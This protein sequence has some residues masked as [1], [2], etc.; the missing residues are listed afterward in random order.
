MTDESQ[1]FVQA[2]FG[3]PKPD[4]D[5]EPAAQESQD[6]APA[7]EPDTT[8]PEQS[9]EEAHGQLL[10]KL[11]EPS[12]AEKELLERLHPRREEDS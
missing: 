1:E 10:A 2:L 12:P 3:T 8:D 4:E 9:P 7:A 11:F 5:P 6:P